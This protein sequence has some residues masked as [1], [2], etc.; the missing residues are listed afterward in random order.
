LLG[1][2]ALALA[3]LPAG[4]AF[5]Q[6][7][8]GE[9]KEVS[10]NSHDGVELK[11]TL[12]PNAAGK[13]D[14]AVVLLLHNF[15]S[16]KGGSSQKENLPALAK[17][18]HADGYVVLSFD[19]RGFGDSK[20]VNKD[21]FWK[22][23]HNKNLRGALKQAETIDQKDFKSPYYPYL[24]ND[25]AAAKAYLDRLN[26][27]GACNTSNLLI[28]GAGQG[29]TL[30]AMWM[31]NECRRKMDKN[32]PGVAAFAPMLDEPE[33]RD[34][35]GAIWLTMSPRLENKTLPI[36]TWLRDVGK[37]NKVPMAFYYGENDLTGANFAKSAIGNLK[38][39]GKGLE[40][41]GTKA[42]KGTRLTGSKLLE[43]T[44]GTDTAMKAY[45]NKVMEAR[46][47]KEQRKR[48]V[49]NRVYYYVSGKRFWPNKRAGEEAPPVD[50]THLLGGN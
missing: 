15:D 32:P 37:T 12:Y 30:G 2:A 34:L 42:V 41:T 46:G 31:A 3:V 49:T 26:D 10:F 20:S 11:G 1:F 29:A 18:L 14:G 39:R 23:P 38:G 28:V 19:F 24:V 17:A 5:G 25:I 45:F 21:K 4:P 50:V 13:R 27:Q 7:K 43:K 36:R 33:S 48:D 16:K 8:K 40:L 35:A 22:F 44:L 9:S 6:G 47:N